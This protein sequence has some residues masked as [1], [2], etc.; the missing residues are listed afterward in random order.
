MVK[1]KKVAGLSS[2]P[3]APTT[4]PRAQQKSADAEKVTTLEKTQTAESFGQD[5]E[6]AVPKATA[7]NQTVVKTSTTT[8]D[9]TVV[10]A[11]KVALPGSLLCC[12]DSLLY[13]LRS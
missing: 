7:A 11:E 3:A 13:R 1:A 4:E 10:K 6:P 2:K 12:T 8:A 9:Q 5:A